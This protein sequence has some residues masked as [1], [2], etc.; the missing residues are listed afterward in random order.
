MRVEKLFKRL[1]REFLK[2]NMLQAVLDSLLFFLTTNLALFLFS[3][4]FTSAG[5]NFEYLIPITF[6]VFIVDFYYRSKNYNIEIYEEKNPELRERLRTARDNIDTNNIV[7]QALFDEI[8]DLS[9]SVSSESIIP[10]KKIVQKMIAIGIISF[11]TVMSGILNFQVLENGGE[12]VPDSRDILEQINPGEDKFEIRN[13]SEIYGEAEDVPVSDSLVEYNITGSGETEQ[14]EAGDRGGE[15]NS[16]SLQEA[17]PGLDGD[18]QLAKEY[19]LAIRDMEQ[20]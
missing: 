5:R 1:K 7:S 14:A 11:L 16:V 18:L 15:P 2:V 6:L 20:N 9:R 17:Y 12:I 10:S 3:V 13:G 8:L 19:S 4:R